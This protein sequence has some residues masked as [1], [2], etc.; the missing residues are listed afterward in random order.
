MRCAKRSCRS[1]LPKKSKQH[2]IFLDPTLVLKVPFHIHSLRKR[3]QQNQEDCTYHVLALL[4]T[5][6]NAILEEMDVERITLALQQSRT[7]NTSSLHPSTRPPDSN[8]LSDSIIS[9]ATSGSSIDGSSSSSNNNP[10]PVASHDPTLPPTHRRD[11]SVS[12][13]ASQQPTLL[14]PAFDTSGLISS[15]ADWVQEFQAQQQSQRG[16]IDASPTSS[17]EARLSDSV[18]GTSLSL[19]TDESFGEQSG[20]VRHTWRL[21][22]ESDWKV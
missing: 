15:S 14:E 10:A 1:A 6:G 21:S 7:T 2:V 20:V 22:K 9:E 17:A 18:S 3:F 13:S 8:L 16:A 19:V 4:P 5:L 12:T 11:S